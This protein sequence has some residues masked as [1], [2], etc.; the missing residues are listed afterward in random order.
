MHQM[1][2]KKNCAVVPHFSPLQRKPRGKQNK[3]DGNIYMKNLT[4]RK[5]IIYNQNERFDSLMG[6]KKE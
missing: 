6:S 2:R 1:F 4:E 3:E 5:E